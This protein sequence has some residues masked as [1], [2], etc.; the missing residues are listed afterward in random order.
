MK[1][2]LAGIVLCLSLF[3]VTGCGSDK[4]KG[5]W[6]GAEKDELKAVFTFDGKG[7]VTYANQF[8]EGKEGEYTI[9]DDKVTIKYVWTDDKTYKFT[10]KDDKLSLTATDNYSPSYKNLKKK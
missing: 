10:I 2:V 1:K 8:V 4:L 9:K 7:K 3:L 6:S 5:T